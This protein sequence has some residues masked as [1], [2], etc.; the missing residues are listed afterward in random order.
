RRRNIFASLDSVSAGLLSDYECEISPD[1]DQ[2]AVKLQR[3]VV[4]LPMK[5][6]LVFNM[7]YY[8]EL[9]FEDISKITGDSV[10]TL[11]T[12]YHYAVKKVKQSVSE[13]EYE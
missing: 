2:I 11:K 1:A 3:T 5:Q 12:N 4:A 7:R 13:L 8:D 10:S 9:S 6:K